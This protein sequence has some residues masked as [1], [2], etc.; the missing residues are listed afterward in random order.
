[1]TSRFRTS[2]TPIRAHLQPPALSDEAL[3]RGIRAGDRTISA[4][5]YDRLYP[6]IDHGLRR[7]LRQR[8]V[9]FDDL[10]QVTFERVV[11]AIAKDRFA[12]RSSLATWASAIAGHVALDALRRSVR[13]RQQQ[14]AYPLSSPPPAPEPRLEA[15][16][17]LQKMQAVLARMKP[18]HAEAVLLVDVLGHSLEEVATITGSSAAATQSRLHRGRKE[19]IRRAG[20]QVLGGAE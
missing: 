20:P 2:P 14:N 12:G 4:A 13:Q 15:R 3:L 8:T 9:D 18:Q 19:L 16:A 17:E 7:V 1:M 5:F 6:A 11:T 10:V